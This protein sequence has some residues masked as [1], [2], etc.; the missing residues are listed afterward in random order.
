MR[1]IGDGSRSTNRGVLESRLDRAGLYLGAV[2]AAAEP[3]Q[4]LMVS[5]AYRVL[6]SHVAALPAE[7][8]DGSTAEIWADARAWMAS[9]T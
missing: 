4:S 6:R 1:Y 3:T 7:Q 9:S 5:T 2:R 8:I